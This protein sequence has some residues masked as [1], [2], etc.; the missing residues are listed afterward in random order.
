MIY[1]GCCDR[2]MCFRQ[3]SERWRH[4]HQGYWALS[5]FTLQE[6]KEAHALSPQSV[7]RKTDL[8]GSFESVNIWFWSRLINLNELYGEFVLYFSSSP[9]ISRKRA[10]EL[11]ELPWQQLDWP[12]WVCSH[13]P[14]LPLVSDPSATTGHG[15]HRRLR[16][17]NLSQLSLWLT[18]RRKNAN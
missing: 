11:R 9:I 15:R 10:D 2:F 17:P 12:L 8:H 6:K 13:N 16:K 7:P 3:P 4:V 1:R 5:S 14:F 18:V